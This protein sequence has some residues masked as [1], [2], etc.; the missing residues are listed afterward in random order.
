VGTRG[1]SLQDGAKHLKMFG[2]E[3]DVR[4]RVETLHGLS[5]HADQDET[6]RWLSGFRKPPGATYLVHGEP[7][8]ASALAQVIQ[9]KLRW[10]VRPA[11]DDE[12]VEI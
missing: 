6:L 5:A 3:V 10:S 9:T 12:T 2:T 11:Q 4:A 7:E 1:R 8:A